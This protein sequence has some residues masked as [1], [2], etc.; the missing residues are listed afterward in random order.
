MKKFL[1]SSHNR[2]RNAQLNIVYMFLIKAVNISINL[3]YVPLLITVLEQERYGVW[4][5]ITT[6]VSWIAFFD[7]GLG[8]GLRN[9]L[10]EAVALNE[11]KLARTYVSTTYITM[12]AGAI[13]WGIFFSLIVPNCN[14]TTLLNATGISNNEL[15][16]L[17][18]WI[19]VSLV[20]QMFLKLIN[21]I[22]YALQKPAA[23]SLLL[24][25][26][27]L[28]AFAGVFLYT[29]L[30]NTSSLLHL[31]IIISLAPPLVLLAATL[32][33]FRG[34]LAPYT[35]SWSHFDKSKVREVISLGANFFWIQL[36]SLFLFQS[37][38]LIIAHISGSAA[39]AEYNIAY[40]YIGLI[41][42]VFAIIAAPFWSATTEAFKR[43]DWGWI[44]NILKRIGW[45]TIILIFVG[46]ILILGA[47]LIYSYWLGKVIEPDKGLLTM[48][49]LFFAIQLN[50]IR[51]GSILNGLGYIKLQFYIT[52]TEAI[53]HIPLAFILGS[54]WGSKGV[55]M[56]LI[57][58]TAAN[59]IWPSI[60]INKIAG[61]HSGIWTK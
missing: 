3:A 14:W 36:T 37:N 30:N 59:V 42:M 51:Y 4:L 40:K 46:V 17:M 61:R 6:I 44:N 52:L 7:I 56:S 19:I 29:Q 10:A 27:Q 33:L 41:E 24:M 32:L 2:T 58:V 57:I 48:L 18:L 9:K 39:V 21:S 31:G 20:L 38:T 15:Q 55:I 60:Q 47:D 43:E 45:I 12:G 50:W 54:C 53:I 8:N 49:L 26:S 16:L 1:S 23:A 22:L 34:I 25:L 35:P 28:M 11:N 13:F 5:T